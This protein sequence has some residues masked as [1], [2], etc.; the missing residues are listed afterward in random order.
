MKSP[1]RL[2]LVHAVAERSRALVMAAAAAS[3]RGSGDLFRLT[4]SAIQR[5][6]LDGRNLSSCLAAASEYFI[7]RR[8][9]VA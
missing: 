8:I 4:A 7:F 2:G 5:A 9:A 1:S 6:Q 3:Y